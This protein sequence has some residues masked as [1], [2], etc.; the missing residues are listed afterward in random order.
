MLVFSEK[1]SIIDT[2]VIKNKDLCYR[3]YMLPDLG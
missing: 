1:G 3:Y 2:I